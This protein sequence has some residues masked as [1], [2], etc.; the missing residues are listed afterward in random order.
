[1]TAA[2]PFQVAGKGFTAAINLAIGNAIVTRAGPALLVQAIT[3]EAHPEGVLVYNFELVTF[4]EVTRSA[5]R[6]AARRA[7][8]TA[9]ESPCSS[10]AVRMASIWSSRAGRYD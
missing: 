9:P 3:P 7:N 5:L 4:W 10:P 8:T 6:S 1:L 2:H